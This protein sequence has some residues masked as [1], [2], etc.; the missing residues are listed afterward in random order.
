L[1]FFRL[2]LAVTSGQLKNKFFNNL[3]GLIAVAALFRTIDHILPK[4]IAKKPKKQKA[5][6]YRNSISTLYYST[7]YAYI[8]SSS[9]HMCA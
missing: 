2:K 6:C 4:I 9:P 1:A 3:S 8:P 5:E 7:V